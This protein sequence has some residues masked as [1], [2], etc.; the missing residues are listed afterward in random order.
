[1]VA[2]ILG[3]ELLANLDGDRDSALALFDRAR[4]AAALLDLTGGPMMPGGVQC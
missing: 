4:A 2:G 3:L 1:V